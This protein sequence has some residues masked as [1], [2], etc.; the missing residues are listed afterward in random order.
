MKIL[1]FG[2]GNFLR[3]FADWM[4]D[5]ANE[6]GATNATV[7]I[8]PP[9]F[10]SGRGIEALARQRGQY[11]VVLE[12][13]AGGEARREVRRISCVKEA[14]APEAAPE[15]YAAC[16]IDPELRFVISNTTEAGIAYQKDDVKAAIPATFPGK[17]TAMLYRRYTHFG[18][19]REKGLIFIPCELI[20]DNGQQLRAIVL[21]HAE[22]NGLGDAFC[23]W[24]QESCI[25]CDSLVDRIVAGFPADTIDELRPEVGDDQMVVKGELYHLWVIGTPHWEQ[26]AR[27]LPLHKAGL[28]VEYLPACRE[29]REKKVRILNGCHT[30]MTPVA[31]LMGIETVREA[32]TNPQVNRFVHQMLE[33]EVLPMIE[34]ERAALKSF[35]DG[36]LERFLNP[37][38]RHQLTSI[39][40][41]S[42]SKWEARLWPTVRDVYARE[43]RLATHAIFAYAALMELYASPSFT[44]QDTDLGQK[45]GYAA[46]FGQEVPGF[47]SLAEEYR[48]LIS[49]KGVEQALESIS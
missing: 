22:E 20:E 23:R 31:L 34:G 41:N 36:I 10:H 39:A 46:R 29:F 47:T 26:V 42:L 11:H 8:V 21:R 40:L 32:F 9:R 6:K 44:P 17:V 12:G 25:F 3:A 2:E 30:A 16:I 43:G 18:G 7:T 45:D 5:V 4:I 38:I 24:V 48:R 35:A 19:E 1:Q 37:Y 33:T 49:S 15:A 14:F 28:H 13:M 27:E